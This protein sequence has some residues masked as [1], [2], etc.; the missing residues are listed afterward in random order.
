MQKPRRTD[1]PVSSPPLIAAEDARRRARAQEEDSPVSSPSPPR[2][3][4][5]DARRV[6][7]YEALYKR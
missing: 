7:Q 1:E 5:E 3:T 6:A 2:F 4:R